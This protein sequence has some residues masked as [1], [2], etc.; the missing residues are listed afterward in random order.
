M[1]TSLNFHIVIIYGRDE[2][3]RMQINGKNELEKLLA[4]QIIQMESRGNLI[5]DVKIAIVF[6][7]IFFV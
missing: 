4:G 6:D 7:Y 5:N 2:N 1:I 3:G